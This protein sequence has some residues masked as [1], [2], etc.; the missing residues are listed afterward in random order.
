MDQEFDISIRASSLPTFFDCSER[1]R[2]QQ[3]DGLWLP[4]GSA[5][6]IGTAVHAGTE[7]WDHARLLGMPPSLQEATGAAAQSVERP[8]GEVVWNDNTQAKA[9]DVAT[10]LVLNYCQNLAE[11]FTFDVVEM[12]MESLIVQATNGLRIRFTGKVDRRRVV[13][14]RRGVVDIKTGARVVRSD[15]TVNV[16]QS[17]GQLAT[18]EMLELMAS[19]TLGKF[20]LLPAMIFG[21]PTAGRQQPA[22]GEVSRPHRILTGDAQHKGAID[23]I[24][25]TVKS[26]NFIG[27]A[28]SYLC[29]AKYCPVYNKCRWRGADYDGE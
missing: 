1:W 3:L 10:T 18:Y 27:N 9:K 25:E 2:A 7:S 22:A 17:I 28:R 29:G 6:S 24:A 14:D 13:G 5:A 26:G 4:S 19:R 16:Q 8:A 23:I 12:P 21:M 11:Q 15:G 20:E